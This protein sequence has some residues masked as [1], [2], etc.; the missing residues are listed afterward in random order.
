MVLLSWR[1]LP[2]IGLKGVF[3]V[4][5]LIMVNLMQSDTKLLLP[6]SKTN[7]QSVYVYEELPLNQHKMTFGLRHGK[8]EVESKGGGE[9]DAHTF[10]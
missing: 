9:I 4:H 3:L 2:L 1:M 8:H 10:S 6:N 5:N 7:S